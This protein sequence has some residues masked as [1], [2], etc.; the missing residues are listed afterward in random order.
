[1][2]VLAT[3]V[4][5][6]DLGSGDEKLGEESDKEIESEVDSNFETLTEYDGNKFDLDIDD[7]WW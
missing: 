6:I 1:M 2:R 3:G 7:D 4:K 5:I